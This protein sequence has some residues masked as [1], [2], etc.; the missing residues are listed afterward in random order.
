MTEALTATYYNPREPASFGGAH[1][2]WRSAAPAVPFDNV[3]EWLKGQDAYTLHKP[4]RQRFSR[5]ITEVGGENQQLQAD[6]IDIRNHRDFNDDNSFILTCVDVFSKRAWAVPIKNKT[7]ERVR[8]GLKRILDDVAHTH[9]QTD[10]GKEFYNE[11]VQDLLRERKVKHFSTED[12]KIKASIVERFNRTLRGKLYRFMTATKSKRFI[13]KLQDIVLAYNSTKHSAT[14]VAP[15]HVGPHNREKIHQRL[16]LPW[17][18][19]PPSTKK[20]S[21]GDH[22]RLA[23]YRSAFKRGYTPNWS[24]ELFVVTKKDETTK[25]STFLI[26]DMSGEHIT[27]SFYGEELQVV[28]KP[29]TF[30]VEAVLRTRRVRGKKQFL[31]KWDGYPDKFNSWVDEIDMV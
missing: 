2:L 16:Y 9:I 29:E 21:V 8:E 23:S 18:E 5:R 19:D 26:E 27:G 31:V 30:T 28:D 7:G 1:P 15:I 25:P 24:V 22:V 6:L 20:I 3:K 14:G 17:R 10:K 4:A 13:H 12:D 11:R